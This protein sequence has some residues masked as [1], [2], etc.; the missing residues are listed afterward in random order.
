MLSSWEGEVH[1]AQA[2]P[3]HNLRLRTV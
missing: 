3:E 1:T 2:R